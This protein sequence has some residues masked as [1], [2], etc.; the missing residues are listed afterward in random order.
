MKVAEQISLTGVHRDQP[1]DR[2]VGE[3]GKAYD[4]FLIYR[5]MGIKRG[6]TELS[7]ILGKH[8]LVMRRWR[9]KYDWDLR[10]SAWDA[11]LAKARDDAALAEAKRMGE[12]Q[13]KLGMDLQLVGGKRLQQF[14]ATDE[15]QQT[16][17]ARDTIALIKEGAELERTAR[18]DDPDKGKSGTIIFNL[19]MQA[20]PKWSPKN[21]IEGVGKIVEGALNAKT[22]T[23]KDSGTIQQASDTA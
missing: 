7:K 20:P 5:E 23:E 22:G 12:R 21:V 1:W 8:Y 19:N 14:A 2:L 15:L 16:L 6:L 18:G 10:V 13:A 17:T 9:L 11:K 3:S 4:A